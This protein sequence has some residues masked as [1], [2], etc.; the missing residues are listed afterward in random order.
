M[1]ELDKNHLELFDSMHLLG[2]TVENI[3]LDQWFQCYPQQHVGI[4]YTRIFILWQ[5]NIKWQSH[6]L[7]TS[8][9]AIAGHLKTAATVFDLCI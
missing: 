7:L 9:F 2:L 1:V 6:C 4:E 5:A 8:S 3:E